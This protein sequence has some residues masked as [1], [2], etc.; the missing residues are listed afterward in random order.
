MEEFEQP[1]PDFQKGFNEGYIIAKHQPELAEQ[2][3]QAVKDEGP[4]SAGFQAG[5]R[6]FIYERGRERLP[7]RFASSRDSGKESK[8]PEKGRERGIEPER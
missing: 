8:E 2:L 3:A 1:D 5:R 7:S 4:R 6:Q